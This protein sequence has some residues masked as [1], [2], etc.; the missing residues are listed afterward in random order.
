MI[1]IQT[2]IHVKGIKGKEITDFLL[3]CNDNDYQ[4]WWKGTHLELHILKEYPNHIGDLVFMD[5]Y[6]GKYRIKMKGN[7]INAIPGQLIIWQVKKIIK[8]P[9]ILTLEL[10]DN[11]EGVLISHTI[12]A[13]FKGILK[14]FDFIFRFYLPK[15]FEKAMDEH[16]AI[17]FPKLRDLLQ[18][19]SK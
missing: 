12:K 10:T 3:N 11:N 15:G 17:E 4:K 16:V 8:L 9:I 13:G 7:V 5:E 6:I 14:V 18:T 1:V 19:G 2:I